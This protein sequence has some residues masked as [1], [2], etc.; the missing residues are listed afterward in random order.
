MIASSK[1]TSF[2]VR[3]TFTTLCAVVGVL[4]GA[5]GAT[6]AVAPYR[7]SG[8]QAKLFY[9][10]LGTFSENVIGNS[11][12]NLWNVIIGEGSAAAASNSTLVLV[13]VQGKPGA[14]EPNRKVR[15]VA[16]VGRK[17]LLNRVSSVGILPNSGKTQAAFWLYDTGTERIKLTAS[18]VGQ[19]KQVPVVRTIPFEAGE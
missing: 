2:A 12:F 9:E 4:L 1:R 16:A 7:I 3:L 8:I 14:Y 18:L 19:A 15:L 13:Q 5:P 6:S 10:T 17:V 11:N